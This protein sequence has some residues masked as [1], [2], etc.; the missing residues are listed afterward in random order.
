MNTEQRTALLERL[1]DELSEKN[2]VSKELNQAYRP[3]FGINR[4][5]SGYTEQ[6]KQLAY[7]L[8][9][10]KGKGAYIWDVDDNRYLDLTM[11]FGVHLF[12]HNPDFIIDRLHK[13]LDEGFMLGPLHSGIGELAKA[14]AEM[15]SQE[16]VAFFN[17]GTEAVI[18]ALRLAKAKTGK[19][20]IAFFVNAY[21]GTADALLTLRRDSKTFA[22][23]ELI[24]GI[25]QSMLNDTYLLD[26]GSES[27]LDF[28]KKHGDEL[29]AVIIEPLQ[30]RNPGGFNQKFLEDLRQITAENNTTLIFDEVISGFRFA[31]GGMREI[32]GIQADITTYGKVIGGGMP[33]GVVAGKSEYIDFTDGGYWNFATNE[34][35]PS[36]MTF[37]AG[38]FCH[39]P[40]MIASS[41]A[42]IDQLKTADG[43]IQRNLNEM[44]E[45][46]IKDVNNELEQLT[47][48]VSLVGYGSL[49][50]FDIKNKKMSVLYHELLKR[51][52]YIW[53]GRNCFLSTAH[54][55]ADLAE[56]KT[57]ILESVNVFA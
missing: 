55:E 18:V 10:D 5:V 43:A 32:T 49:F 29:A 7:T 36:K 26:Y 31:N 12:G 25:P 33:I 47:G 24:P 45:R 16:R 14:I 3:Y 6:T 42:V 23:T 9:A 57:V 50:R 34:N 28:V 41:L 39:H 22:A 2:R 11:G 38:T 8:Y 15:T 27:A 48:G 19:Q 21:H 30:S 56:L 20:K 54:S 53:E 40:M 51:G 44:S 13:Q 46:F 35:P 4:S 52:I 37:V 17:S 1:T